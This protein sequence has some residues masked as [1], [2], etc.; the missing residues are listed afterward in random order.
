MRLDAELAVFDVPDAMNDTV[1]HTIVEH[2]IDTDTGYELISIT[3]Q[4]TDG[5]TDVVLLTRDQLAALA[6]QAKG[7]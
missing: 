4:N 1:L 5:P 6:A 3:Q 2:H 7:H